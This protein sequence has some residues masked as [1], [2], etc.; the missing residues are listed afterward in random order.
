MGD[1]LESGKGGNIVQGAVSFSDEDDNNCT[2]LV[3]G[4]FHV[5]KDWCTNRSCVKRT[6]GGTT[7]VK[8]SEWTKKTA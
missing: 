6:D 4:V 7:G 3:P 8:T 5:V 1:F 2:V